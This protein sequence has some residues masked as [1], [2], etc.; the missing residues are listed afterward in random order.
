M[1]GI[2]LHSEKLSKA[3]LGLKNKVTV[4]KFKIFFYNP[5]KSLKS[6]SNS[7]ILK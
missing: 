7:K 2:C 6:K 4:E 1:T 3:F 5:I